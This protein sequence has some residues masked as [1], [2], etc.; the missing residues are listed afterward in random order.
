MVVLIQQN[1]S[2]SEFLSS[3]LELAFDALPEFKPSRYQRQVVMCMSN[4]LVCMI[5]L[6][7]LTACLLCFSLSAMG[8]H[9]S[10]IEVSTCSL[11]FGNIF[12]SA[13]LCVIIYAND[14]LSQ[15]C[16]V[17]HCTHDACYFRVRGTS[18]LPHLPNSASS[19][20]NSIST[21]VRFE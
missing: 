19:S 11:Y 4:K 7:C 10:S 14:Y 13:C 8:L 16:N 1:F 21:P 2:V 3:Y 18:M 6:F 20:R 12:F 15:A 17:S 9:V 5:F